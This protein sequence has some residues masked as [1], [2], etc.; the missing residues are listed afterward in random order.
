MSETP[1]AGPIGSDVRLVSGR[2]SDTELAAI[3]VVV[4][5]M[6]VTSRIEAQERALAARYAGSGDGW[7]DPIHRIPSAHALRGQPSD[8]AWLFSGR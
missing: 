1:G 7:T 6:S 3:A 5:A 8:G 2:L 4:S